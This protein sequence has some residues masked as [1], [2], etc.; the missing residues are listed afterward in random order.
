M[1]KLQVRVKEKE[2]KSLT[3]KKKSS[4]PQSIFWELKI[5]NICPEQRSSQIRILF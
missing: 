1:G 5:S 4:S 3:R 2:A